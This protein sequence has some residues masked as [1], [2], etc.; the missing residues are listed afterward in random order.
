MWWILA[1]ARVLLFTKILDVNAE[2]RKVGICRLGI[3]CLILLEIDTG[4]KEDLAQGD[5]L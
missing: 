5:A 1:P 4:R 2:E 3:Q